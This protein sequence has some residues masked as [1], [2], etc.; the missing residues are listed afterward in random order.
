MGLDAL[1]DIIILYK[2]PDDDE[3]LFDANEFIDRIE[4]TDPHMGLKL[5]VIQD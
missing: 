1:A 2:F 3:E 4:D 5:K